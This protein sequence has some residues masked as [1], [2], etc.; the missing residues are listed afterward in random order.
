MESMGGTKSQG[1]QSERGHG[2]RE[3]RGLEQVTDLTGLGDARELDGH[4]D[5]QGGGGPGP[6]VISMVGRPKAL[7]AAAPRQYATGG[8][9]WVPIPS[10]SP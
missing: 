1:R 4:A 6:P 8:T 2:E 10:I 5:A 3:S 7:P 9:R